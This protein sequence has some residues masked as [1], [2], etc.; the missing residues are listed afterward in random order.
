MN[1]DDYIRKIEND[2]GEIKQDLRNIEK[3]VN[4]LKTDQTMDNSIKNFIRQNWFQLIVFMTLLC[5]LY[6]TYKVWKPHN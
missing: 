6:Y 5:D 1:T 4:S 2:I 3:D